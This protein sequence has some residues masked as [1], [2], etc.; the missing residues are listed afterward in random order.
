MSLKWLPNALTVTRCI[1]AFV[2]G[3]MILDDALFAASSV[4]P[5]LAF[6]AVALTDFIDGYAARRLQ[7]ESRFGALL[8]PIADKLLVGVA[9]LALSYKAGWAWWLIAPTLTILLRDTFITVIR[10]RPGVDL[11]VIPLAKWK[12]ALEM[13]GIGGLLAVSVLAQ[14]SLAQGLG[15]VSLALIW[16]AAALSLFTLIVYLKTLASRPTDRQT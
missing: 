6:I 16:L 7:A 3:W 8:D 15:L 11:P 5:L 10:L 1:L 2:V 13:I 14:A 4:W 12:T 9:L